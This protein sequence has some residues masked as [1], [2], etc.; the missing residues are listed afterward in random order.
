MITVQI[1]G[2]N[3]LKFN[4]FILTR[5]GWYKQT[6]IGHWVR[7]TDEEAEL[8]VWDTCHMGSSLV[9]PIRVVEGTE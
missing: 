9:R 2:V 7:M 5:S 6:A 4:G 8:F 1:T 3:Q